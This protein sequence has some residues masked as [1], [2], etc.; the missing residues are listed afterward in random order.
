IGGLLRARRERPRRGTAEQRHECAP[1]HQQFLPCFE[2]EDST[3]EDLL[4]CGISK[5]PLSAVGHQ[6]PVD[7]PA[8]V[9]RCPLRSKSRQANACFSMSASC[10]KR[11]Y[12]PQH[13]GS[14][15]DHLVGAREQRGRNVYAES[16][17]GSECDDHIELIPEVDRQS[18]VAFHSQKKQKYPAHGPRPRPLSPP[19]T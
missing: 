10:Q 11:A 1:F 18:A 8:V 14:L 12:A 2:A 15:F 6:R 16:L 7:T 13:T 5:E 19:P 17:Y 9:A 3:A 4:H